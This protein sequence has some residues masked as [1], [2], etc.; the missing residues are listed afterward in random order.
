MNNT[1]IDFSPIILAKSTN[2]R[3]VIQRL[4]KSILKKAGLTDSKPRRKFSMKS[5]RDTGELYKLAAYLFIFGDYDLCYSVCSMFDTV[6]FNG[7]YGVWASVSFCRTMQVAIDRKNGNEAK[8]KQVLDTILPYE[9]KELYHNAWNSTY[10]MALRLKTEYDEAKA[11]LRTPSTVR[12]SIL[13]VAMACNHYIQVGGL[14]EHHDLMR[15]W[16]NEIAQFLR[17]EEK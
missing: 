6:C 5:M 7:D 14:P 15:K 8:A 2:Q 9:E 10:K 1:P 4:T 3:K 12:I 17:S 13:Y 16:H 11:G